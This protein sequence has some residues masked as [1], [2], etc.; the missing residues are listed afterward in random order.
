M[1][2]YMAILRQMRGKKGSRK[3]AKLKKRATAMRRRMIAANKYHPVDGLPRQKYGNLRSRMPKSYE[4]VLK[5]MLKVTPRVGKKGLK[6]FSRFWT[7]P[8]PPE[9]ETDSS[10]RKNLVLVGAGRT[11][12]VFLASCPREVPGCKKKVIRGRKRVAFD[13]NGRKIFIL[14]NGSQK[15]IGKRKKFVG[16]ATRT[17]YVPTKEIEAAGSD[18]ANRHWVHDHEDEG[19]RWPKVFKDAAGNFIYAPGTLRINKWLRR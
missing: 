3:Y 15:N 8:L 6:K 10:L 12:G 18:K 4:A 1:R 17:E 2:Q 11:P 19:G 13:V 14:A 5:H 7:I 9:I 16:W